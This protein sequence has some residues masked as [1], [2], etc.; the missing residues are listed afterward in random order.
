MTAAVVDVLWMAD[1]LVFVSPP[2]RVIHVIRGGGSVPPI[3]IIQ[4]IRAVSPN[5][6]E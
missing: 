5:P 1:A 6:C 3:V 4:F 2:M